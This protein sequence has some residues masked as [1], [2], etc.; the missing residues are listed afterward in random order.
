MTMII[1]TVMR[2]RTLRI[3]RWRESK[4]RDYESVSGD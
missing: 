2:G 4:R 3:C 1:N